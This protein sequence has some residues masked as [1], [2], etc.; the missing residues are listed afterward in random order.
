VGLS[1][2]LKSKNIRRVKIVVECDLIDC[3]ADVEAVNYL[4][5]RHTSV[6]DEWNSAHLAGDNLDDL[7]LRPIH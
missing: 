7:T 4:F 3:L 6:F 2:D 1:V 5:D